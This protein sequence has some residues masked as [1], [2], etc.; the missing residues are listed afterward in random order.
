MG[1]YQMFALYQLYA[2]QVSKMEI[3]CLDE[4]ICYS[5]LKLKAFSVLAAIWILSFLHLYIPYTNA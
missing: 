3:G 5:T 4:W 2:K 1:I